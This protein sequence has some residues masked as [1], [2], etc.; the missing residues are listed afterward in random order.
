M[1][2]EIK[3]AKIL[4]VDDDIGVRESLRMILKGEYRVFAAESVE[5]AITR[6]AEIKPD[7]I[8]LDVRMPKASGLDFLQWIRSTDSSIPIIVITA[9]PSSQTTITAFRN[10]AFDYIIKPFGPSEILKVIERACHSSTTSS[11]D[12]RIVDNLRRAVRKNFLS[13]TESLLLA[14]DAKDSYTAGHSK[15]VDHLFAFIAKELG[16]NQ[17]K[18][19][20][21]RYGAFLHDIGKIGISD[22]ILAKPGPL[23]DKESCLM[24]RHPDIGYEI[25]QPINFLKESLQ[26]VRYHHE[27]YNG[28]GYPNGLK[29]EEIPYE[30][31]IFSITDSYDSL[32]S[33]RPY[34]KKFSHQQALE[35]I[36]NE[37]GTHFVPTLTEKVINIIENH[38]EINNTNG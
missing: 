14:I 30:V 2:Q 17:S 22:N 16:M 26:I 37:I 10:G 12:K 29:G 32:T 20:V 19:E 1:L 9:F 23:T 24:A 8:L 35:I 11:E 27:W 25:L 3:S 33:D 5:E 6:L 15:R 36:R 31:A 28:Q 4:V 34:R 13:T 18:I 38:R 7:V 21:L